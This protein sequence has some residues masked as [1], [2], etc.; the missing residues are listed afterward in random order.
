[1]TTHSIPRETPPRWQ[2]QG[3]AGG[4]NNGRDPAISDTSG[5]QVRPT[6]GDVCS[7]IRGGAADSP[8]RSPALWGSRVTS[9]QVGCQL[10]EQLRLSSAP[11]FR[12]SIVVLTLPSVMLYLPQRSVI[13]HRGQRRARA[14]LWSAVT[15]KWLSPSWSTTSWGSIRSSC[16]DNPIWKRPSGSGRA[17][18]PSWPEP[19]YG[20]IPTA[21]RA[22]GERR[23][24]TGR[25][26]ASR[27]SNRVTPPSGRPDHGGVGRAVLR[28][29]ARRGPD[30]A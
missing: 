18:H 20:S 15:K 29:A 24:A 13:R 6:L 23:S 2:P 30:G 26:C 11:A 7:I 16:R 19:S 22:A 1:M 17:C 21:I 5:L 28:L 4:T 3:S 10:E 12:R 27:T 25:R 8:G 9:A 14:P